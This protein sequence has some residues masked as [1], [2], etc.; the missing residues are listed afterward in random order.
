MY[1][2]LY[3]INKRI[4]RQLIQ[5]REPPGKITCD[6]GQVICYHQHSDR[7]K[8]H[9]A[10]HFDHVEMFFNAVEEMEKFVDAQRRQEKGNAKAERVHEQ[11]HYPLVHRLLLASN[12]Q[13]AGKDRTDTR[14]PSKCKSRANCKRAQNAE[15]FILKM[16]SFFIIEKTDLENPNHVKAKDDDDSARNFTD[17][18]EILIQELADGSCG[19]TH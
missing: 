11:K 17:E 10:D 4:L 9:T 19:S 7:Y 13:D 6:D 14:C 3:T 15:F 5:E 12:C 2:S 8:H 16:E 18:R 1:N